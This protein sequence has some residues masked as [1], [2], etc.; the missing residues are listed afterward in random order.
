[1]LGLFRV[2]DKVGESYRLELLLSI[3]I[4]DV[5][6]PNL[7][8]RAATDPLPG[9]RTEPPRPVVVDDQEE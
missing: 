6:Y 9:Q 8:R 4:H 1:M 5:F 2:S 7:L 3:R